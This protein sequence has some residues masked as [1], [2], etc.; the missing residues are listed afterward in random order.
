MSLK[1]VFKK[2]RDRHFL[3]GKIILNS[4][5]LLPYNLLRK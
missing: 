4:I 3:K 1:V 5:I 2:P